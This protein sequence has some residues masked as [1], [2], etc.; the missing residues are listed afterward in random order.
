MLRRSECLPHAGETRELAD[1]A[2]GMAFLAEQYLP[3]T[4]RAQVS[5]ASSA[6]IMSAHMDD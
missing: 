5:G 4:S 6:V 1:L 3:K 2:Y